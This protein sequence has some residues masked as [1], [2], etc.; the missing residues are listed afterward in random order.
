MMYHGFCLPSFLLCQALKEF[1]V[2]KFSFL[3]LR[4]IC[5]SSINLNSLQFMLNLEFNRIETDH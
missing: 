2:D 1:V 4:G 3:F 5:I